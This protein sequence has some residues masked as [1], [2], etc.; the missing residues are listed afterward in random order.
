MDRIAPQQLRVAA[1]ACAVAVTASMLSVAPHQAAPAVAAPLAQGIGQLLD[2]GP[3]LAPANL[4]QDLFWWG[5]PNPNPPPTILNIATVQPIAL[6]PG[7]SR[8]H[9][10]FEVCFLGITL[11]LSP[12]GR[13]T[14][15]IAR[16]C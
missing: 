13:L 8:R 3:A 15:T 7:F 2:T 9:S 6:L 10:G 12:Y 1:A 16:G 5:E 4:A 11:R 14:L